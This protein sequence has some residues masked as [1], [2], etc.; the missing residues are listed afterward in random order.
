MKSAIAKA[1]YAD[2]VEVGDGVWRTLSVKIYGSVK[3]G[4][5]YGEYVAYRK[6]SIE[7]TREGQKM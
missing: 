1:G 4:A 6:G 3:A 7:G 2:S 5:D